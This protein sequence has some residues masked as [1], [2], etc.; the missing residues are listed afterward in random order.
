M[1]GFKIYRIGLAVAAVLS[2]GLVQS[3]R[4][5]SPSDIPLDPPRFEVDAHTLAR[6]PQKDRADVEDLIDD[7]NR[8]RRDAA[9]DMQRAAEDRARGK[10]EKAAE[11]EADAAET[12]A[13]AKSDAA[14]VA[15]LLAGQ[16]D[17]GP[18]HLPTEQGSAD[19]SMVEAPSEA[20]RNGRLGVDAAIANATKQEGDFTLKAA[21]IVTQYADGRLTLWIEDH[22]TR[23]GKA[24][25]RAGN[26]EV[27]LWQDGRTYVKRLDTG[28]TYVSPFRLRDM[29]PGP[30]ATT[31][32]RQLIQSG[33]YERIGACTA[34]GQA[35]ELW[36]Y[37]LPMAGAK[38]YAEGCRANGLELKWTEFDGNGGSETVRE[39]VEIE[40]GAQIPSHIAAL[41]QEA[42]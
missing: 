40:I 16:G 4:A 18:D 24:L 35:G 34:A 5:A 20:D 36:R 15:S 3:T 38:G 13:D 21:R 22:G 2:I 6:L 17:P 39:V 25:D 10:A 31:P 7:I 8:K 1:T 27:A 29:E 14:R 41:A 9:E 37:R 11:R 19:R 30:F 26:R 23:T 42:R 33:H 28:E 12:W 32:A